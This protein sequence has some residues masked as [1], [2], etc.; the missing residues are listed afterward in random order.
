MN[1]EI[2]GRICRDSRYS[3][4]IIVVGLS[5]ARVAQL[6]QTPSRWT[7][8]TYKAFRASIERYQFDRSRLLRARTHLRVP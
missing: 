5:G 3:T 8:G 7:A 2:I 1:F 6:E 4:R